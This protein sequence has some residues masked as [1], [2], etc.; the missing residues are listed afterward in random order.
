MKNKSSLR[1]LWVNV[2]KEL[3]EKITQRSQVRNIT[4]TKYVN[5]ALLR[6]VLDESK[7]E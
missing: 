6:Y 1:K 3:Y 4:F 7:Y 2:N 5:R